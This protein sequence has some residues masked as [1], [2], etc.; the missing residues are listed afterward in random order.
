MCL[1]IPMQVVESGEFSALCERRGEQRRLN[2]MLI[3]PQPVGTWVLAIIDT[4]REVL[5]PAHAR[6]LDDAVLALEAA[7]QG[8][9]DLDDFFADLQ[10][11]SAMGPPR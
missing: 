2:M 6:Q 5:D 8:E 9:T 7:T 10:L 1:G 3:G 4:A 11:P